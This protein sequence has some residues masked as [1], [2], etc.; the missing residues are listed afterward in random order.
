MME[1]VSDPS[2]VGTV[3]MKLNLASDLHSHQGRAGPQVILERHWLTSEKKIACN[4]CWWPELEQKAVSSA[5][6]IMQTASS[7]LHHLKK[8]KKNQNKTV[9]SKSMEEEGNLTREPRVCW[10]ALGKALLCLTNDGTCRDG[11]ISKNWASAFKKLCVCI[12]APA[13]GQPLVQHCLGSHALS[14]WRP[15]VVAEE[16]QLFKVQLFRVLLFKVQ[17]L[18]GSL[19]VYSVIQYLNVKE[20]QDVLLSCYIELKWKIIFLVLRHP[21]FMKLDGYGFAH[22]FACMHYDFQPFQKQN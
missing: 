9:A 2:L 12:C 5:I 10:T 8:Q 6:S 3:K 22:P 4:A 14:C 7:I 19:S 18:L 20:F 16:M 21:C 15:L 17:P 1:S 11:H 13:R